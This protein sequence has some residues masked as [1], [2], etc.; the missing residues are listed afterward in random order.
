MQCPVCAAQAKN[1]IPVTYD[2]VVVGCPG[3]GDY[4][5]TGTVFNKLLRLAPEHRTE[6]LQKAKERTSPG[7]RPTISTTCFQIG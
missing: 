5:V 7:A 3:C 6:A 1:L 4:Q 2:G